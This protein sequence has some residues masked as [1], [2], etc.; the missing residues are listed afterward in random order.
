MLFSTEVRST[1]RLLIC[2]FAYTS[3]LALALPLDA[4]VRVQT[5]VGN[6]TIFAA[7]ALIH[8]LRP[9]PWL[10]VLRDWLPLALTLTAYRQMAWF[11]P[12]H[13]T[14][15]L[16]RAWIVWDRVLLRDWGL[17][18]AIESPGPLLPA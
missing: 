4:S 13:H 11:A 9:R 14:Y 16:E 5:L 6:L 2:Y 8:W 17:R 15:E 12:Q 18:A 3:G 10:A 1:E 7:L